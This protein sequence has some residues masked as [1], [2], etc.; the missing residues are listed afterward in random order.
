MVYHTANL[1]TRAPY[2]RPL[3]TRSPHI[4]LLII[5]TIFHLATTSFLD[6]R[7]SLF[8]A[9]KSGHKGIPLIAQNK[10]DC[11]PKRLIR[12]PQYAYNVYGN[13][14]NITYMLGRYLFKSSK[15]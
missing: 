2:T 1:N 15:G 9:L 5:L 7:F 3:Y 10:T 6:C 14:E 12:G 8:S 11:N 13:E 4:R